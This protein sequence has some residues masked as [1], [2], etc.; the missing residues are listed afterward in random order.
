VL[1]RKA[2]LEVWLE[3][4]RAEPREHAAFEIRV[5]LNWFE[6]LKARVKPAR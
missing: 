4:N 1:E 3:S 6:E 5:V 2:T